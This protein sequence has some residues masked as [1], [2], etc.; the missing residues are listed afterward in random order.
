MTCAGAH[1]SSNAN[2]HRCD[3]A[4]LGYDCAGFTLIEVLLATALLAGGLVL[5][6]ATLRSVA[7]VSQRGEAIAQQSERIRAVEGVLRQRLAGALPVV[8]ESDSQ[9]GQA[10]MFVGEPQRMR[11]VA[12]VPDYLGRGG[13]YQHDLEEDGQTSARRLT[14]ALAMVQT[15]QIVQETPVPP[16]TMADGLQDVRFA[17]RGIDP[18]SGL[19]GEWQ[20][21]WP[22]PDRLPLLVRID[23]RSASG[24]WPPLLVALPQ[25]GKVAGQL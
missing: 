23:I 7:A 3:R 12:D 18:Q 17:Y 2:L 13:P 22:W 4:A 11:F 5:A 15:G 10:R 8:M 14:L 25:V 6:F 1:C 9:T 16:E 20:E 19:L 24:A 21:H